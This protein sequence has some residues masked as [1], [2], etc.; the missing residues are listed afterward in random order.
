MKDKELRKALGYDKI[1]Y[2]YAGLHTIFYRIEMKEIED[3][4]SRI[5]LLEEYLNIEYSSGYKTS[6]K[7]FKKGKLTKELNE[8]QQNKRA[9]S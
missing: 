3:L 8:I 7:Y 6:P 1:S 9:L 4:K 2:G 5:R